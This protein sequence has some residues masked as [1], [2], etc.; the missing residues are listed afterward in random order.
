MHFKL[1][2]KLRIYLLKRGVYVAIYNNRYTLLKVL[3]NV[4]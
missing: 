4:L 1:K 3:F 2:I